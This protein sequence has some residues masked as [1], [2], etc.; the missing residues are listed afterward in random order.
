MV[1]ARASRRRPCQRV[2][3]RWRHAGQSAPAMPWSVSLPFPQR[4]RILPPARCD[5]DHQ[6][7]D[8]A[9]VCKMGLEGIVLPPD[10]ETALERVRMQ[11][12]PHA[13]RLVGAKNTRAPV[14]WRSIAAFSRS[15]SPR[16]VNG[17]REPSGA[18]KYRVRPGGVGNRQSQTGRF[19][20]QTRAVLTRGKL[21][22][23]VKASCLPH[24]RRQRFWRAM[25]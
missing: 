16:P 23:H 11:P 25:D 9:A 12:G 13:R 18:F 10:A 4:V 22:L 17:S 24:A 21:P 8:F 2:V 19:E 20:G 15:A 3:C 7:V 1:T 14:S 6:W 5:H